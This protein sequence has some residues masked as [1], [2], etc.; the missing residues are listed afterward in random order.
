[1]S[2]IRNHFPARSHSRYLLPLIFLG[3]LAAWGCSRDQVKRSEGDAVP[4]D[5]KRIPANSSDSARAIKREEVKDAD[6][7]DAD[8]EDADVAGA[9]VKGGEME[10]EEARARQLQTATRLL[11]SGEAS[12]AI[13]GLR[14][15]VIAN[16][17]DTE[18][19][20]LLA[21]CHAQLGN[22]QEA[23][24][25]LGEI[26]SDHPQ[27]GLPA[28][29]QSA[30][31]LI[32][33]GQTAAAAERLEQ[34]LA[35]HGDVAIV[36]RRLAKL[37]NQRGERWKASH[38]L[39]Y[40][41]SVGDMTME[42]LIAINCISNPFFGENDYP[43]P[44]GGTIITDFNHARQFHLDHEFKAA[45]TLTRSL[46][47]S[48]PQNIEMHAFLG[49]V[50]N[51]VQDDKGLQA[52]AER[53]PKGIDQHPEYWNAIGQW[54]LRL[55]EYAEATRALC[56]SALRDPTNRS[57]YAAL[58]KSLAAIGK[59]QAS[60]RASDRYTQLHDTAVALWRVNTPDSEADA[61]DDLADHLDELR[62]H[63]ESLLWRTIAAG[64]R[65]LGKEQIAGLQQQ[66]E[67][68]EQLPS[69]Q[70]PS[71]LLC[72]V[73]RSEFPLPSGIVA[74]ETGEPNWRTDDRESTPMRFANVAAKVGI[75][76]QFRQNE[77]FQ[78]DRL[79]MYQ[80]IGGGI[81]A[82][83]FDLDGNCDLLF[84]QAKIEEQ[85]VGQTNQLFRNLDGESF[86]DVSEFAAIDDPN[87]GQG[88]TA[89]DLNQDG[90]CDYIVCNI[91]NIAIHMNQ[92]DGTFV[93]R[94]DSL[95]STPHLWSSSVAVAD[96]VGNGLPDVVVVNYIDDPKIKS[97]PC[98]GPDANCNPRAFQPAKDFFLRMTES[99]EL[100]PLETST[101]Q[102]PHFG[103]GVLVGNL[104][105]QAGNDVFIANDTEVNELWISGGQSGQY[106][107]S[108][109]ALARGVATTSLGDSPGCMGVAKGDFD[110][111]GFLDFHIT[112]FV[113]QPSDLYLQ[114]EHR[115]FFE[116]NARFG[117]SDPTSPMVGFG[118]Q[119]VD[120]DHDGWPDLA[121]LN[122]HVTNRTR[123][124]Q[125]YQ[126]LPQLFRGWGDRFENVEPSELDD[127]YWRTPNLGRSLV[128]LDY[129]GDGR[130]DLA[131]SHLDAPAALLRNGTNAGG[132]I[133]FELRGTSSERDAVGAKICV[134]S[135]G[136]TSS[137]WLTSG[138]GFQCKNESLLHFG[139]ADIA[140][141]AKVSQ[142]EVTWPSGRVQTLGPI[143]PNQ[144]WLIVEGCEHG[145]RR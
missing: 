32:Q 118:T 48:F 123:L 98:F 113:S 107:L 143:S 53:L 74:K 19:V 57:T 2:A 90:F 63:K 95:A 96:L 3:W 58:A 92:G 84:T 129:D 55:G 144:R 140:E 112:N 12:R 36:H 15:L 85:A 13:A 106:V 110:R 114:N 94:T 47:E 29:G 51:S 82:G 50:L 132:W 86:E 60:K 135:Q 45:E 22:L 115:V 4:I 91:G 35:I 101:E 56:E 69:Q 100:V 16:N 103:L 119:A 67:A 25:I 93:S 102:P 136:S 76:F 111:N 133:Q 138:D 78:S 59:S 72:G 20:F 42:E 49:R 18:A 105:D 28:L 124:G 46:I 73:S 6:V 54:K 75:D 44:G 125:D 80:I 99:G 40:L 127:S 38:H 34:I 62:R 68:V 145:F 27:A 139:L 64:Q 83:D 1:M 81:A 7:E 43:E 30:D 120:F 71:W 37:R 77:E 87:H 52:W 128:A 61:I 108:E 109:E 131:A 41:L 142:V 137:Q 121:V 23:V 122:G 24:D 21:R 134:T 65:R 117:L 17:Q 116:Q 70:D 141:D 66:F 14:S 9:D 31:W 126:M 79:Y 33:L 5:I 39:R 26:D 11:K 8:V 89:A 130:M 88:V 10:D 104:D 97:Q